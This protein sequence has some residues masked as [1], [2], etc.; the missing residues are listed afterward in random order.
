MWEFYFTILQFQVQGIFIALE[1]LITL[2]KQKLSCN[3]FWKIIQPFLSSTGTKTKSTALQ[4]P[5]ALQHY[6]VQ[7]IIKWNKAVAQCAGA[8]HANLGQSKHSQ[9]QSLGPIFFKTLEFLGKSSNF[10]IINYIL[11]F[12]QN[13]G[14]FRKIFQFLYY[15][16]YIGIF[17]ITKN[18]MPQCH[19]SHSGQIM[20]Y[21]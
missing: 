17:P 13:T 11:E 10:Q 2:Q 14:I 9:Q 21:H 20:M 15:K 1:L 4:Q 5:I 3:F 8:A 6:G 18:Q 19:S 12:F 16:L 7:Y